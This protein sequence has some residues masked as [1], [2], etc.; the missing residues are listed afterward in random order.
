MLCGLY[1]QADEEQKGVK[2]SNRID[3]AY[4]ACGESPTKKLKDTAVE[5]NYEDDDEFLSSLCGTTV[6]RNETKIYQKIFS[7]L[8]ARF[9]SRVILQETINSL[10]I[11]LSNNLNRIR[12]NCTIN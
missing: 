10:S 5:P 4:E 7:K 11:I 1:Y 2:E 3:E 12:L 9:K 6:V 8:K